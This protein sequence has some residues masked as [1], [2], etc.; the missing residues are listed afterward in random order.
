MLYTNITLTPVGIIADPRASLH[1]DTV[2]QIVADD[3]LDTYAY[4]GYLVGM[5]S[6]IAFAIAGWFGLNNPFLTALLIMV[7]IA[8]FTTTIISYC[9]M[10]VIW[11][12]N[13][14][15]QLKGYLAH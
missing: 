8:S 2:K 12:L 3:P 1:Q 9:A 10:F 11:M 13:Q 7:I 4:V 6:I 5:F 14:Y 15:R